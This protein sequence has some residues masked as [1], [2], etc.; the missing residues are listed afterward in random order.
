L[1]FP[2]STLD[3]QYGFE[4]REGYFYSIGRYY[5]SGDTPGQVD[6]TIEVER[7]LRVLDGGVLVLCGIS[8]V[9]SQ[10]LTIDRQP[11]RY[12]VPRLAFINKRDHQG[13]KPW[14]VIQDLRNTLKLN[15]AAL[16]IPVGLENE[17]KGVSNLIERKCTHLKA[18]TVRK[19]K[20]LPFQKVMLPW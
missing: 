10:S 18:I 20:H 19:S 13:S 17:H 3:G 6:F 11:K 9:Q 14:K 16:Q 12:N 5:L 1:F 2:D 15:A 4:M 8:G 7:A